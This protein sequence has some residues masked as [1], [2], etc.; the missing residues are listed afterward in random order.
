MS[1]LGRIDILGVGFDSID[2]DGAVSRAL[3][4]V[5]KHSGGW[6]VTP[7]PEIVLECRKNER[8]SA[9][10]QEAALVIP[11][12]IGV[13]YAARILGTPLRE[14][15]PGID[16]ACTLMEALAKSDGSVYLFGAKPGVAELASSELQ[17]RFNG[18]RICGTHD[19]YFTDDE[20]IIKDIREK[21]PDLVLVCLGAP[22]QELWMRDHAS[23]LDAGLLIGLGGSLDV[24]AGTVQ[25]APERWRS[26][27]LEWLYRLYREPKRIGRMIR[28]PLILLLALKERVFGKQPA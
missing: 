19:G 15:I 1:E 9:A 18:L 17:R 24:F 20:P 14:K 8:L 12:G 23:E 13:L 26:L 21:R 22:K 16:F 28:L 4:I 7:N 25:R 6:A 27:G 2:M 10:V 3:D 5:R 11:D